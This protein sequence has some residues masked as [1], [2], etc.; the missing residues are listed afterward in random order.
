MR[1][2][3]IARDCV[4]VLL[5]FFTAVAAGAASAAGTAALRCERT[6]VVEM[7]AIEQ[8][9]V[10]NRF[11]AFNPAGMLYAL[12][13]DVVFNGHRSIADG[14]PVTEANLADA[15][16]R[17]KLR[18][19]KR[20]RPIV[21][22]A[23]EGD[24]LQVTLHNLLSRDAPD[25]IGG[26]PEQYQVKLP[27]PRGDGSPRYEGR[28]PAHM[29]DRP[30]ALYN[31]SP[32]S[33]TGRDLVRPES[34]S[35]DRPWTRAASFHVNGLD[36]VPM[37]PAECPASTAR[38]SWL[39]GTDGTAAGLN[40]PVIH[41]GTPSELR[42]KLER[43]G[44]LVMPG[45][46]AIYRL[47]AVREGTYFAYSTAAM[48]GGEGD[49]GQIGAGLFGAVNV[50]PRHSTWYRSQVARPDLLAAARQPPGAG[51]PYSRLDYDNARDAAGLP[52]LA[53][54]DRRGPKTFELVH[55]DLNA[56]V[57]LRDPNGTDPDNRH[58]TTSPG[59]PC[60]GYAWGSACGES[61]REF[62]VV[63]HD[64]VKAV[65]AFA[66]LEDET[67]PL[68][69]IKDGMGINYGVAGMGAMVVARQRNTGPAKD[70]LE[71]RAEEFFLSSWAGG[72]PALVL[73]WDAQGRRPIGALYPDD[74]SN[75]HHSYLGDPVRF[76]NL[77]AGPKETHVFHLHAHQ[78]VQDASDGGSSYLDSQTISPGATF[79]YEVEFGGSG[80][81]NLSPGD[82][83]FH[84]HL[85]PH[86]AQGM[87]E[88][89]RVH[90][91][92]EDGSVQRRLPDAEVGEGIDMPAI[93]PLP[94]SVL[95]LMPT[96]AFKGYPFYI[97]GEPGH[98]P[99]QPPLD[100]DVD[101]R[102]GVDAEGKP[103]HIDGGLQ[104]HVL[105][106]ERIKPGGPLLNRT[107]RA[108]T[109]QAVL[110]AALAKGGEIA[111]INARR[112]HARNKH[113][114]N[115]SMAEE[116]EKI[117][118]IRLLKPEGEVKEATAMKF[119]EGALTDPGFI[120]ATVPDAQE[121]HP[122]WARDRKG[123]ASERATGVIG[124]N[125]P[126]AGTPAVF[127]VNGRA[128]KP[129]A[130]FAD[131][132][133]AGAP[134]R[135]YRAG[136]IQTELT[137]NRHGWFDPQARILTLEQD[138]ADL[139]DPATRTRLPEP[140]F[141]RAN[142]GDC[143][144]FKHSN[145]VPNALALD[146][147]QIFTPTDTIGQHIH[148]VK[149]DV[150][151]SD[152]SGNGWNYEDG[153]FSPEEVRER[154]RAYNHYLDALPSSSPLSSKPRL[155]LRTHPL[156]DRDCAGD[157]NCLALQTRGRCPANAD[158]LS[159]RELSEKYPFCGA[160]RTVQRWYADP[161]FD[162]RTG[163]D[164]TL[165][166]VFT[167]DHFGPS[168]HQQHG[169]YAALVVEPSN[170]VWLD[171]GE[172][173]VDMNNLC[174][175]DPAVR[176]AERRKVIGGASLSDKFDASCG[177]RS[178]AVAENELRPPLKLREDG[179]PTA[180]RANIVSPKCLFQTPA[181]PKDTPRGAKKNSNP[182]DPQN[183][184]TV[185][186]AT[187]SGID[188]GSPD[189][190]LET[191]DTR[192]EYGLAIA[193]F[194]L[195]YN[196]AL[197]PINPE[198]PDRSQLRLG[199]RQVPVNV[200]KPLAISSE[201]PGSQLI[202]YRHEPVPLR[203]TDRNAD[204]RTESEREEDS[205]LGGFRYTQTPCRIDNAAPCTGDMSNVF[206]SVAH[207]DRDQ[208][209][210]NSDYGAVVSPLLSGWIAG[211]YTP[212]QTAEKA[213]VPGR[214]AAALKDVEHWR[215][216]FHCGLY[217]GIELNAAGFDP[218]TCGKPIANAEPW[219]EMGDPA[220]PIIAGYEGDRMQLR[221]VQGAQ[222]AQHVFAMTRQMWP[223]EPGNPR[224]GFTSAQSLGISEH[225]EF[226]VRLSPLATARADSLYMSSSIDK[227][228]DGTWGLL[229]SYG[230]MQITQGLKNQPG[231]PR[232]DALGHDFAPLTQEKERP[233][234][235]HDVIALPPK[236]SAPP[237]D[238][239]VCDNGTKN[240]RFDISVVKACQLI[241]SCGS[242]LLKGIPYNER[243]GM[244]DPEGIVFVRNFD[245][246]ASKPAA[247][248]LAKL[249]QE[250]VTRQRTIEPLVLRAAAGQCINV[251]LRNL[252]P[253]QSEEERSGAL[254]KDRSRL[255]DN[256]MAMTTD[257]FNYNQFRSTTYVG[258]SVPKLAMHAS[259]DGAN[260]G[261]NANYIY[262]LGPTPAPPETGGATPATPVG[263][264]ASPPPAADAFKGGLIGPGEQREMLWY[265]GEFD[266]DARGNRRSRPVEF[267]VL[268]LM[269]WGDPIKHTAHGAVGAL[270]IG[271]E[272]SAV[273]PS[274]NKQE[275]E[276]DSRTNTSATVCDK[277]T[278]KVLYRDF[279]L[280]MQD[281]VDAKISGDAV[282]N[283]SG[284]EE[285]D[286]YGVKAVNYRTEPLWA[287][288][289][290]DP[291]VSFPERNEFDYSKILSSLKDTRK[292]MEDRCLSG[293]APRP[294]P[295]GRKGETTCE[296]LTPLFIAEAGA[297]IRL[298]LVHPG[299][300]TRQ[301]AVSLSGHDWTSHPAYLP[302]PR[303]GTT[304]DRCHS[305]SP[306]LPGSHKD[307]T[308][309]AWTLQGAFNGLGPLM[310]ADL[311]SKAGGRWSRE[312]DYLWRS[313]ASFLMDG[314]IWGLLRVLPNPQK[315]TQTQTP[316]TLA[317][318][319][320]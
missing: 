151:S 15:P 29:K 225:F 281:A 117:G 120:P 257:G 168:S 3:T 300:R 144:D 244:D 212:Q 178:G 245:V 140:L 79:S 38:R 211:T 40:K 276:S 114:S 207:A 12:R 101:T 312:G 62:T 291:S 41:S 214:I 112:V 287:R 78:W 91:V 37:S 283:L 256:F 161:I 70:C 113:P 273:C 123:Y 236:P 233:T 165:R 16:G 132:C 260:V 195:L 286:D 133:P 215:K 52:I 6:V 248:V 309:N 24:C 313:E 153:T 182:L 102:A 86:F 201:D 172:R 270:V 242:A 240:E 5:A 88:L 128:P 171:I 222:E 125:A 228:W 197:E 81:L 119:H 85:Y 96:D 203:I 210:A 232:L 175:K 223:R 208:R 71:C 19:G 251:R 9:I 82:S 293:I 124:Q 23:N 139:I 11:G 162:R 77:H 121:T 152:G 149:F 235:N 32:G 314:G 206:S 45:Q 129:G 22:R 295:F 249:R 304:N 237:V 187:A 164:K 253:A 18:P 166:T 58:D 261:H 298:R 67:D 138:V 142:S 156:F 146:D 27:E 202:N 20:P 177:D 54:L 105:T 30:G 230:R 267:G 131:P 157:A 241:G 106:S 145:F 292:G 2:R 25:D 154:V 53:M 289:A 111:Q 72:D 315:T 280:V 318:C 264:V 184:P 42:E 170:S 234:L 296:P 57:A 310:S 227:L 92:F 284:S 33:P 307:A 199:H 68:H 238:R 51:H 34:V 239:L 279:V 63:M 204:S 7:V 56:I 224:S 198:K 247:D 84:C 216:R 95:A 148:L 4:A 64:E 231:L 258:L 277:T 44:G 275:R 274:L 219:R 306:K 191:N 110:E 194:A 97:A 143:I 65:Q 147:F 13:R 190:T 205:R 126:A 305:T 217:S 188:C 73:K 31:Q 74:P 39:C 98:R 150:T 89:W 35:N 59:R 46:S 26:S 122:F 134:P 17:V 180:A 61:Y 282:A 75:V 250:F 311:I 263:P 271:P 268:P 83:I 158:S 213:K 176:A 243:I 229:R 21:L 103:K 47:H 259:S 196:T 319:S 290:G 174:S 109:N 186:P 167:H 179:G 8:A 200:P 90:D 221:L 192:R 320:G 278:G 1:S 69:A 43:Q 87:W 303:D 193:D 285:P 160:Q 302:A 55:T 94:G 141:F 169:L 108:L 100:M 226:D 135:E 262:G 316:K 189:G 60:T 317:P 14:T 183:D 209:I 220:T 299:G 76:R 255:S 118:G 301:Q 36:I 49:G 50:Q 185:N 66:E 254:P 252:L 28:V 116:W 308:T 246:L 181:S 80:N 155:S 99:P 93:V 266:L 269:S 288:S 107:E 115:L 294:M 10:L 272:N 130:P 104:R 173:H 163:K 137:V 48:V 159:L 265:A 218:T 297:E 127:R 136:V